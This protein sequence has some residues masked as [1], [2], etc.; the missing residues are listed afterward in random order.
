LTRLL[1]AA[2]P[3]ACAWAAQVHAHS[4]SGAH[5]APLGGVAQRRVGGSAAPPQGR[6]L[7]CCCLELSQRLLLRELQRAE[8]LA[9]GLQRQLLCVCVCVCVC[10]CACVCACVERAADGRG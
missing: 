9:R 6:H 3:A 1:T 4:C 10:V 5:L 2:V 7:V 8:A